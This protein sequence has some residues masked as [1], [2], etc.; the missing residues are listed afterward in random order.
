MESLFSTDEVL[1]LQKGKFEIDCYEMTITQ[2]VDDCPTIY[3]GPGYIRQDGNKLIFKVY[4]RSKS[5]H[6]PLRVFRNRLVAGRSIP[7]SEFYAFNAKD[8]ERQGRIWVGKIHH[9]HTYSDFT[10]DLELVVASGQFDY[11][12]IRETEK[13]EKGSAF[14][15]MIF[16]GV[17]KFC[18][19]HH[20]DEKIMDKGE[21][22]GSKSHPA[23]DFTGKSFSLNG[24]YSDGRLF[25]GI[26]EIN[27]TYHE[28]TYLRF[29]E[30]IKFILGY[31]KNPEITYFRYNNNEIAILDISQ[32]G[33]TMPKLLPPHQLYDFP[34]KDSHDTLHLLE[35]FV[36]YVAEY[37]KDKFTPIGGAIRGVQSSGNSFFNE[38]CLVLAVAVERLVSIA[39]SD[40]IELDSELNDAVIELSEIISNWEKADEIKERILKT[41]KGMEMIRIVDKLKM[42]MKG[43]IIKKQDY[44]AWNRLRN[45]MAHA[46]RYSNKEEWIND[47]HKVLSMFY[48]LIFHIIGYKGPYVEYGEVGYPKRIYPEDHEK[49]S[50]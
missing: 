46:K 16:F 29:Q 4:V 31:D 6:D 40:N 42:L 34:M 23:V 19:N 44:N 35:L 43:K 36:K 9:L 41:I 1:A 48:R 33:K 22:R 18:Y 17:E 27:I 3:S 30:A 38:K 28:N 2:N 11:L 45:K 15:G 25:L 47:Y 39:T 32:F 24:N 12:T 20:F 49:E 7:E 10:G 14:I 8:Y 5:E 13:T 37:P 21:I 50:G 26:S